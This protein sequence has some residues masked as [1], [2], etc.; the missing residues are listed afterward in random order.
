MQVYD[1]QGSAGAQPR[2]MIINSNTKNTGKRTDYREMRYGLASTLLKNGYFSFDHGD[3]AHNQTWWYDEYSVNLG[4]PTGEPVSVKGKSKYQEDA[5]WKREYTSGIAL[6][7]PTTKAQTVDLTGEYEKLI[8]TQDAK[9]NNGEIVERVNIPAK[10]GLLMLK[11][12]QTIKN[13]VFKNGSFVRFFKSKG[14][15]A[16]TGFFVS[17]KGVLGSARVFVGDLNG[18][19][20]EEKVVVSGA[21]LEVKKS[22]GDSLWTTYPFG[23]TFKGEI[24]L[25]VGKLNPSDSARIAVANYPGDKVLV[26]SA[27]GKKIKDLQPLGAKFKGGYSVAIGDIDSDG[28]GELVVGVGSGKT[29][30]VL[31]YTSKLDGIKKRFA[32]YGKTYTSGIEVALGDMQGD[33]LQEVVTISR[34]ATP[35]VRVSTIGGKKLSEFRATGVL[36]SQRLFLSTADVNTDGIDEIVLMN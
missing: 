22:N 1:F 17:E 23:N 24:F 31:M 20:E 26:Y 33:G 36:E 19:G 10:D 16:R 7:N 27:E 12:I 18:D 32:P 25:A 8:G 6:V 28:N 14:E 30:E 2:F 9:T 15:K 3:Q 21:K 11:T 35:L 5:V 34:N 4:T 29:S 13:T